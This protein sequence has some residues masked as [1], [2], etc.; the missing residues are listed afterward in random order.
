V[1]SESPDWAGLTARSEPGPEAPGAETAGESA[2]RG[3]FIRDLGRL[4][5]LDALTRIY[6]DAAT[7]D[8]E[9]RLAASMVARILYKR[10][11]RWA[12]KA[13]DEWRR[14]A[15]SSD[16]ITDPPPDESEFER[17]DRERGL[18]PG[19]ARGLWEAYEKSA[20]AAAKR[21]EKLVFDTTPILG[22]IRSHAREK[23]VSPWALLTV[24]LAFA[25]AETPP[26]LCLPGFI[27]GRGSLN[28]FTALVG[29][30]GTGKSAAVAAY[31]ATALS[32]EPIPRISPSSGEGIVTLFVEV[33]S[34]GVQKQ[35]RERVISVVDEIAT[36]GALQNRQGSTL[37]SILRSVWSGSAVSQHGAEKQRRRN[38][39]QHSYRFCLVAGV[40]PDTAGVLLDDHGAGT[41]QR[42][43]WMPST[44]SQADADAPR[45]SHLPLI[46][47]LKS[48]KKGAE[49]EFP[50]DVRDFVR[51]QHELRMRG[52][53]GAR[54]ALDGHA[55]LTRLKVA[56]GL[57]ILHGGTEVSEEM[58]KISE[59]IMQV[60]DAVRGEL[61]DH[62]ASMAKDEMQ[63]RG[64]QDAD[65]AAAAKDAQIVRAAQVVG[66]NVQNA[67]AAVKRQTLRDA[68]GRDKEVI[69]QAIDRAVGMHWIKAVDLPHG[70][71]SER[72]VTRFVAGDV[73]VR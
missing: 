38:L 45:A 31:D 46:G 22:H 35:V 27:G 25:L 7:P 70:D 49:I 19:T 33:D 36:M 42:F 10:T 6:W 64:R 17:V 55:L 4:G 51:G 1:S 61:V 59:Y 30:S 57:A 39:E 3:A 62:Q 8:F 20:A 11:E 23:M 21:Y 28:F 66:R 60:S 43:L 48:P 50:E 52:G 65:R 32:R 5:N 68:L 41:P 47:S 72:L 13:A 34:K 15:G 54:D 40:Q 63:R 58:W 44:D 56:A 26:T 69:K 67:G 9:R 37:A 18:V 14:R 16:P 24:T 12:S 2:E 29:P 73:K 53:A 71:G